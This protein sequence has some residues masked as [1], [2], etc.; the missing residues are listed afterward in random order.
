MPVRASGASAPPSRIAAAPRVGARATVP[1]KRV[2]GPMRKG[3]AR[4]AASPAQPRTTPVTRS[5]A[6]RRREAVPAAPEPARARAAIEPRANS[7]SRV[8]VL[9]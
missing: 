3:V 9:K 8:R 4:I 5:A 7:H 1:G 6:L 2:S